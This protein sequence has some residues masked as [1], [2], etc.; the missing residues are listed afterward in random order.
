M[1][2]TQFILSAN[3]KL[4]GLESKM[5]VGK[6]AD[7]I[8]V[9]GKVQCPIKQ[10][11]H[12]SDVGLT[13]IC[14]EFPIIDKSL[15]PAPDALKGTIADAV[16]TAGVDAAL[17]TG[18]DA[19]LT[20]GA[21]A[22]ATKLASD[23]AEPPYVLV[24]YAHKQ[25]ILSYDSSGCLVAILIPTQKTR[26]S[27]NTQILLSLQLDRLDD[28][29][30]FE[31]MLK[32][33]VHTL[34]L[35][36]LTLLLNTGGYLSP[37]LLQQL[38]V[39][40]QDLYFPVQFQSYSV[41]L[42]GMF[43]L[44]TELPEQTDAAS[45]DLAPRL[46]TVAPRTLRRCD[47]VRN[48]QSA[49]STPSLLSQAY[50]QLPTKA[51]K[52]PLRARPQVLSADNNTSADGFGSAIHTLTGLNELYLA[53]GYQ[54]QNQEF[55]LGLC[56]KDIELGTGEEQIIFK[57]LLFMLGRKK[58]HVFLSA[59]GELAFILNHQPL[60]F[61]LQGT[62]SPRNFSLSAWLKDG[63]LKVTDHLSFSD[64]LLSLGVLSGRISLTLSAQLNFNN[65]SLFGAISLSAEP[66]MINMLALSVAAVGGH[67]S[68]LTLL[69]NMFEIDG[70]GLTFLDVIA[71]EDLD[72]N[73]A[74]LSS[75]AMEQL[76]RFMAEEKNGEFHD[77]MPQIIST[78]ADSFN[79]QCPTLA[80]TNLAHVQLSYLGEGATQDE[81]LLKD[82]TTMRYY[83]IAANGKISLN[84]QMY[85]GL[86]EVQL[87]SYIMPRGLFAC[88]TLVLFGVR[89]RFLLS[90]LAQSGLSCMV[91]ISP[92]NLLNGLL[93]I[94]ASQKQEESA[95]LLQQIQE[96]N[97]AAGLAASLLNTPAE[98]GPAFSLDISL[99]DKC[100]QLF[101]T[102]HASLLNLWQVDT[103]V[104]IAEG[105]VYL[106]FST[107]WLGLTLTI[108]LS[109]AYGQIQAS[110]AFS[111]T[112]D[113]SAFCAA[114]QKAQDKLKATAQSVKRTAEQAQ[115]KLQS[116]IDQVGKLQNKINDLQAQQR[117]CKY[118][119][120]HCSWWNFLLKIFYAGKLAALAIA[121]GTVWLAMKAAQ[122]ALKLAQKIVG[123][124]G[125][126]ASGVL[127]AV[128]TVIG[129]VT[130][131]FMLNSARL[132]VSASPQGV[133]MEAHLAF[134]FFGQTIETGFSLGY[135]ADAN[136]L[137]NSLN[138]QVNHQIDTK[139][140]EAEQKI[141]DEGKKVKDALR[142]KAARAIDAD[143][144]QLWLNALGDGPSDLELPSIQ[145]NY[146]DQL[147]TFETSTA[148]M[149]CSNDLSLQHDGC[150]LGIV[151]QY[152]NALM[153]EQ[154][155]HNAMRA[156]FDH[157]LD[158]DFAQALEVISTEV[159]TQAAKLSA[160]QQRTL[161]QQL[162]PC[163]DA[164][165]QLHR[166]SPTVQQAHQALNPLLHHTPLGYQLAQVD[167]MCQHIR[168][169]GSIFAP[170]EAQQQ[171]RQ[172]QQQRLKA[173]HS[174][175]AY[176]QARIES[177]KDEI[178]NAQ[179]NITQVLEQHY[180]QQMYDK[181][182]HQEQPIIKRDAALDA[183]VQR[184]SD[185]IPPHPQTDR[186]RAGLRAQQ[187]PDGV[188]TP[189]PQLIQDLKTLYYSTLK[190]DEPQR[191]RARRY[192]ASEQDQAFDQQQL[193][194][195]WM[196]A[197]NDCA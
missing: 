106:H 29:N 80:L 88:G 104:S 90:C 76:A 98:P 136:A 168:T 114:I 54:R 55:A 48:T 126:I 30:S 28:S 5:A 16:L 10:L 45:D 73:G 97:S 121:E 50:A 71:V 160:E 20:A 145:A 192:G 167:A 38:N 166:A 141:N 156:S 117:Q 102:G 158:Q 33:L 197:L 82:L 12:H 3:A 19:M 157:S 96:H 26:R 176:N 180:Q 64:L 109:C 62:L 56:A 142:L 191:L 37:T 152:T 67:L 163:D 148:L 11:M 113:T 47:A 4:F 130:S 51:S 52:R 75:E 149:L 118:D 40:S 23:A 36:A 101:L 34:H 108:D 125:E 22:L 87:G 2:D 21:N 43:D 18:V 44:S 147:H 74:T 140:K 143:P 59:E 183:E 144:T 99:Q 181:A 8:Y 177:I 129:A 66:P 58:R 85:I 14:T 6:Q 69:Q 186:A 182:F 170:T 165:Q 187:K 81:Y 131:I 24:R 154:Q 159:K 190:S 184:Y 137:K 153:Q 86:N 60:G 105:N 83:H 95:R 84:C 72:L 94:G 100:F 196:S 53:V 162:R 39:H 42:V 41:A 15:E 173:E 128:A 151:R 175:R 13:S 35:K 91:Q 61:M 171:Q 188:P 25:L 122:G 138:D 119:L 7:G 79:Q 111:V 150:D 169:Q 193:L 78:V 185:Q 195:L 77:S 189:N 174:P 194:Y 27:A 155:Q 127:N 1:S 115:A 49:D 63:H 92:I 179:G 116:A 32:Q 172:V 146:Q 133:G 135:T 112:I 161:K 120:D 31:R 17:T 124:G 132:A 139:S 110:F 103:L 123:L 46:T 93:Y 89:F 65:L 68:L 134:T 70:S 57:N 164:M 178:K 9:A 107:T